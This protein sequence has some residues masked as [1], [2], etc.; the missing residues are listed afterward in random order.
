MIREVVD[1]VV[2]ALREA[3]PEI[4]VFDEHVGQALPLPAFSVRV[5][6]ASRELFRGARYRVSCAVQV[7]GFLPEEEFLREAD[8][9][10]GA[11]FHALEYIRAGKD[12]LR[13]SRMEGHTSEGVLAFSVSYDWFALMPEGEVEFMGELH[14]SARER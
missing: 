5:V 13:G 7:I 14:L 2:G 9:M 1:G 3:F 4:P 12:L 8:G 6:S 10:K 11:L